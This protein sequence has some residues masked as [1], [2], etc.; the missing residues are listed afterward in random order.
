[1]PSPS[2]ALSPQSTGKPVMGT[3]DPRGSMSSCP[4]PRRGFRAAL[5]LKLLM[6]IS[7]RPLLLEPCSIGQAVDT[8]GCREYGVSP[9][10]S[11]H[12][13]LAER[14]LTPYPRYPAARSMRPWPH[15]LTGRCEKVLKCCNVSRVLCT[16]HN[17]S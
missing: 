10:V 13:S 15:N 9:P 16:K 6:V 1:M 11:K 2:E 4:A 17:P 14:M 3:R 12:K 8:L 7:S 5:E